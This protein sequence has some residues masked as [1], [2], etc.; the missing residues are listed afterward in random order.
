MNYSKLLIG[1]FL[2]SFMTLNTLMAQVPEDIITESS[3]F[4]DFFFDDDEDSAPIDDIIEKRLVQERMIL[5]YDNPREVD[6]FWERRIWRIIDVREKMN[7]SF[8]YPDAPFFDVIMDGINSGKI[9]AFDDERF[10]YRLSSDEIASKLVKS[11]TV[12][13]PLLDDP[14]NYELQIVSDTVA[15]FSNINQFRLKE[16]WYFDSEASQLRVRILGISPLFT[17]TVYDDFGNVVDE[18]T[19]PLFWLYYPD[20]RESFA[21]SVAFNPG[22]DASP[23]SW[24]DVFMMRFFSSYIF[25]SSNVQDLRL[26]D[27]P[28]LRDNG[29]DRLLESEKIK[30]EIF[31][32]EHDLWS[33]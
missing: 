6:I 24:D 14:D 1:L 33:W 8:V 10:K 21:R 16:V 18:I 4:D 25:K 20:C 22:N 23:L 17:E 27:F 3:E 31:N 11:D 28:S 29:V 26:T 32:F 15:R 13:V 19:Y 5:P 2:M 30:A 12:L 9:R 7:Q